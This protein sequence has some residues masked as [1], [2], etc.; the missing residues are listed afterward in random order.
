MVKGAATLEAHSAL[1]EALGAYDRGR[2]IRLLGLSR[3]VCRTTQASACA[4]CIPACKSDSAASSAQKLQAAVILIS[5]YQATGCRGQQGLHLPN[6][7]SKATRRSSRKPQKYVAQCACMQQMHKH[8]FFP[9]PQCGRT[10]M[11][12]GKHRARCNHRRRQRRLGHRRNSRRLPSARLL[13]LLRT[14]RHCFQ[15]AQLERHDLLA[16]YARA[17]RRTRRTGAAVS[18]RAP[19]RHQK[20]R[21]CPGPPCRLVRAPPPPPHTPPPQ[22]PPYAQAARQTPARRRARAAAP[23][24]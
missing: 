14:P 4:P 16:N 12:L 1:P 20:T 3:G 7:P 22:A 18:D 19:R 11:V 17:D 8:T 15:E 13:L 21:P 5:H 24:C 23:V 9:W 6:T 2:L 10:K